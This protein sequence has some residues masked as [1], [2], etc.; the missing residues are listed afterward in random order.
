[1]KKVSFLSTSYFAYQMGLCACIIIVMHHKAHEKSPIEKSRLHKDRHS[2]SHAQVLR[3]W[4]YSLLLN[5][6]MF[7]LHQEVGEGESYK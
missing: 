6:H 5:W 7:K 2:Q 3:R 4:G 1:M